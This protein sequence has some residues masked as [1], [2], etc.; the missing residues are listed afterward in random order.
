MISETKLDPSFPNGQFHIHGFSEPYRFDRNGNGGGILLYIREDIPSKVILTKMT[1][2]GFFV[3]INLRKKKWVFCCTY[4]PKTSLISKHLNEIGKNLDLLLSK[5]DNFML[6]GDLNA[7]PS[8]A[9]VSDFCEIYNLK[10]LIKDKTCFKNPT[11]P[12]CIDLII[13][14][15][16][17]C[18]QDSLVIETGL[19]YFHKMSATVMKMYYTKQKPSIVRYRKFKNFCND[20]FIKDIELLLSKFFNQQHVSF[21]ILKESVNIT[22]DKHAPLKK[23]Y[24][25]ANLSPFMNKKLSREIMKRSR[26]RK[27]FLNTK[28]DID[29]KAYNKQ[30]NYVVSL[31]RNEKKNFYSS[32]D[33]KVVTDN[34]TFWKTVKPLLSEKVTK[35]SKINLVEDDKI[36]SRDDQIAKKF[37]E[38]FINISILNMPSNGFKCP[39]S[40]EQYPILKILYKYKNHPSIKLIKA[41]NNSQVFKFSQI[42]I[43][44]VKKSF[45]SLD[46]KK[47]SQ[48]D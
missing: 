20:F 37:S 45:Q 7:E 14:N 28:S 38:Y 5:Y 10:Q 15:R 16:P 12:T 39:D 6:I 47:A 26:L 41:K 18:F 40:S 43:E 35:H 4:N 48:K 24:V 32:L 29:R 21:K 3:E 42:D 25:R 19:S 44:E 31:L 13:T 34:R 8:E 27:K 2:E 1:I 17:K 11:K 23:R 30:R 46:L 36:I 9:T 33:T 22:L